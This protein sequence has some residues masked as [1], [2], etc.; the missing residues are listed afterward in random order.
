MTRILGILALGAVVV[1]MLAAGAIIVLNPA[2]VRSAQKFDYGQAI[3]YD[4]F[5]FA[6]QSSERAAQI[7]ELRSLAGVFYVVPFKVMN[8][9]KRVDFT[10]RPRDVLLV[11]AAGVEYPPSEA[12]RRAWFAAHN[13]TDACAL[14]LPAGTECTTVLVYDV[15]AGTQAPVIRLAAGGAFGVIADALLS[16]NKVLQLK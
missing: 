14:A 8:R 1:I 2:D 12:G 7:G 11:D 5:A 6:V 3:Q 13:T 10:F 16:G 15:P 9:A 4:D